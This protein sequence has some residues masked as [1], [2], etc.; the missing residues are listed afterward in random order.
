MALGAISD[1]ASAN[2]NQV[3]RELPASERTARFLSLEHKLP[4][5]DIKVL[6]R[7]LRLPT[8]QSGTSI[9]SNVI[10]QVSP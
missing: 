4:V 1:D 3:Y 8:M 2:A 7:E 10:S 9:R 6:D 5:A